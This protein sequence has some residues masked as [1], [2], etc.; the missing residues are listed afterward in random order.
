MVS[1]Y[2]ARYAAEYTDRTPL[3]T[4]RGT[5]LATTQTTEQYR[6]AIDFMRKEAAA[7]RLV[8][9]VPQDIS[10][11]FLSGTEAPARLYFFAPGMLVPGRMTETIIHEIEQKPVRYVLWSNA[12]FPEYGV[13]RFSVDYDREFGDYLTSHFHLVGPLLPGSFVDWQVRFDLWERNSHGES[14]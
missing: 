9:S 11:Y 12:R 6:A 10:L 7:G 5:I 4:E 13:P 1:V 14:K 3:V 2:A 8:L